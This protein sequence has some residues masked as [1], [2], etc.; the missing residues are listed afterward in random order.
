MLRAR[1]WVRCNLERLS[2]RSDVRRTRRLLER[3]VTSGTR[4]NSPTEV[5][6]GFSAVLR[7][8]FDQ[9]RS[10]EIQELIIESQ[11]ARGP[12]QLANELELLAFVE[13]ILQDIPANDRDRIEFL[14]LRAM[15]RAAGQTFRYRAGDSGPQSWIKRHE[16]ELIYSDPAGQWMVV[17]Q[18]FWNLEEPNRG[19]RFGDNIA[20]AAVEN[21][22]PGE[23]EG[24]LNCY[25]A[26][27]LM[28]E[29]RYLDL[30]PAGAHVEEALDRF[31]T[32]LRN[33]IEASERPRMSY[34]LLGEH[35]EFHASF[36]GRSTC[37]P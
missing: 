4:S 24:F 10:S 35:A 36:A 7:A 14:R 31:D 27:T 16:Q 9:D 3:N 33:V 21:G 25:L 22:L 18:L 26:V 37:R 6:D 29:G 34:E 20:W 13:R 5:R 32:F 19:T 1:R 15:Q 12:R 30:Y 8:S 23:C 17:S 28:A 11:L 2:R